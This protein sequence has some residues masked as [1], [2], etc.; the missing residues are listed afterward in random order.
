MSKYYEG[1]HRQADGAVGITG[2]CDSRKSENPSQNPS[3]RSGLSWLRVWLQRQRQS[4]DYLSTAEL[5]ASYAPGG[6]VEGMLRQRKER[7]DEASD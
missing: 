6:E 7:C 2:T 1:D 5:M 4:A 3:V